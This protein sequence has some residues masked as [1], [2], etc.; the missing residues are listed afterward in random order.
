MNIQLINWFVNELT[1]KAKHISTKN[2]ESVS[3]KQNENQFSFSYGNGVD[4]SHKAFQIAFKVR[5]DN[6]RYNLE[7]EVIYNFS[8]NE[9][10]SEDFKNSDFIKI[11]A[12]AIAFPYLRS[13]I[14]LITM[15]SGY[16]S[17]VL[18]SINFVALAKQKKL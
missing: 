6:V 1:I 9:V 4:P 3:V 16:E 10:F 2:V 17:V 18:P 14:T 13:Y 7:A 5:L 15:Q 8:T 11:N 12:P